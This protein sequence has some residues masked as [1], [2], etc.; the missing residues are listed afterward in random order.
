MNIYEYQNYKKYLNDYI[1]NLPYSGRGQKAKIAKEL[2]IHTAYVSQVLNK[3][4]NFTLEQTIELSALLNLTKSEEEYL[5]LLVQKERAGSKK[6]ENYFLKQINSF[7]DNQK[8]LKN[9]LEAQDEIDKLDQQTYYSSW[10]YLA[11]HALIST[12]K[13]HTPKAIAERLKI[14]V[15][16]SKEIIEF[17]LSAGIIEKN[18]NLYEIGSRDIHLS[19]DSPMISKHHTNWRMKAISSLDARS[20]SDDQSYEDMHYSGIISVTE[21]DAKKIKDILIKSIQKSRKIISESDTEE[22]FCY[23]LDMFKI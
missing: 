14:S 15:N 9:R 13:F 23:T 4:A 11:V 12:E 16:K 2:R 19:S 20:D 5:L 18:N 22:I 10:H 21:K 1:K 8:K 6:L 7:V 17:L 3:D